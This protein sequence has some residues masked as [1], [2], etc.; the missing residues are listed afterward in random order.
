VDEETVERVRAVVADIPAGRVLSYGDVAARAGLTS[1]RL[2]GRIMAE[3]SS[4][5][6]WHRVLRSN[7]TVS[8]HIAREQLARLRADGVPAVDG[9]VS[10]RT[11]RWV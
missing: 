8:P 11:Y 2:V 9:R 5:L 7:G 6:P 1:A 4:D 10:M 3:D